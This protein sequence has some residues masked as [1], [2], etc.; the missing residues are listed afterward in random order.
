[1]R[2]EKKRKLRREL[3]DRQAGIER[4]LDVR[5][6]IGECEGNFLNRRGASFANVIARNRNGI[7]FWQVVAAPPE[8]VGDDA[9]G[10]LH[11][12]NIRA[13]SDVLLEDIVLY[14]PGKLREACALLLCDGDVEAK[15]NGG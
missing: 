8:N 13:T 11:R 14:R 9:H 6:A 3:V 10:V 7:P 12:I 15:E 5:R 2:V 1:M 4:G